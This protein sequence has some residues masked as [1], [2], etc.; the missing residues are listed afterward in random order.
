MTSIYPPQL[1][2]R[3][4]GNPEK[5]ELGLKKGLTF[6]T[7]VVEVLQDSHMSSEAFVFQASMMMNRPKGRNRKP[8]SNNTLLPLS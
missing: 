2:Q 8:G 4:P 1:N 5:A 7:T 3:T 6:I